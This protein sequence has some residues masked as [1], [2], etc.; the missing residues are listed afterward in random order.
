MIY[1]NEKTIYWPKSAPGNDGRL[2]PTG[3]YQ[4][5]TFPS[6]NAAKRKVRHEH[7]TVLRGRPP[8]RIAAQKAANELFTF[9]PTLGG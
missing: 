7:L 5:E 6:I 8:D 4:A 3:L 1:R 2:A 9:P